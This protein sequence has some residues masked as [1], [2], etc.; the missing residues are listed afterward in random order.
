MGHKHHDKKP[1]TRKGMT[2][3]KFLGSAACAAVGS[4]TFLSSFTSLGLM[5]SL[6]APRPVIGMAP[7]SEYKAL[8][9]ILLAGG[10]DSFNMVVP[11]QTDQYNL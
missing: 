4:T 11:T 1:T 6:A 10:N 7:P 5:N 2:R 8:V 3:R 9:C